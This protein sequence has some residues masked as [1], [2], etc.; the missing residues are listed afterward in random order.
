VVAVVVAGSAG[1]VGVV[2]YV[3]AG[4][5][6]R[7]AAATVLVIGGVVAAVTLGALPGPGRRAAV[8]RIR[9][10]AIAGLIA[11]VTYDSVR[12][13]LASRLG[14]AP[15]E[16]WA[17]F[18]QLLV[19]ESAPRPMVL[20]AGTAYHVANGLGFAIAFSVLVKRPTWWKGLVF[21]LALEAAMALLYP[22]WL[23]IQQLAEFYTV[24][25][26]GHVAYGSVLGAS[27]A[28]MRR[29]RAARASP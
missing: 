6:L 28:R 8:I 4:I 17:V 26:A 15:F 14:I 12:I 7:A 1:G 18:G 20:V 11:T 22:S 23:R 19:G 25:L 10:G 13:A 29:S 5:S 3:L 16:V 24:S 9:H 2:V 27:V 21:A